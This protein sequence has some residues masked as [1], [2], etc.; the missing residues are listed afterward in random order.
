MRVTDVDV[1]ETG[2]GA[3][4]SAAIV[5][6]NERR[7]TDRV[8][9]L[10]RDTPAAALVTPGDALFAASLP[11]AVACGEDLVV[12]AP[13]SGRLLDAAT[14]ISAVYTRR[15]PSLRRVDA[16]ADRADRS[17]L[18]PNEIASAFSG[19]VDSF[20]AVLRDRDEPVTLL[21]TMLGL[22]YSHL[23]PKLEPRLR[24]LADA[25]ASL[26]RRHVIVESNAY[27][28]ELKYVPWIVLRG[29]F[30]FRP[31]VIAQALALGSSVRRFHIGRDEDGGPERIAFQ[32]ATDPLW[33]TE[34]LEVHC[35][36]APTRLDKTDT[37]ATS[38]VAL[39]ALHVCIAPRRQPDNC[40]ICDKCVATALA[41]Q[42]AG[43]IDHCR[44]LHR[45]TPAMVRRVNIAPGRVSTYELLEQRLDDRAFRRAVRIA[46]RRAKLRRPLRPVGAALRRAGLRRVRH[47]TV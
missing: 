41:L 42:L 46:L 17:G 34:S 11:L 21:L 22:D 2:R 6:G 47:S 23:L 33:S 18:K 7:G 31:L 30:T 12:E 43:A 1:V 38:P 8:E 37:V 3:R 4:I 36:W 14:E 24:R 27:A 39:N 10:Y 29:E 40:G 26:G 44:T 13:V 16:D 45:V 9:F 15:T 5:W 28:L 25:A 19:G 32:M 20:Y 35:D